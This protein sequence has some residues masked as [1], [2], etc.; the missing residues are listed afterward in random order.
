M[1]QACA[2]LQ[3]P[4][5]TIQPTENL[6]VVGMLDTWPGAWCGLASHIFTPHLLVPATPQCHPSMRSAICNHPCCSRLLSSM[7]RHSS[8]SGSTGWYCCT[9][10]GPNLPASVGFGRADWPACFSRVAVR[11]RFVVAAFG[12]QDL[13]HEVDGRLSVIHAGVNETSVS[14][15]PRPCCVRHVALPAVFRIASSVTS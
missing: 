3:S 13:A 9:R 11:S 7:P 4:E 5:F 12:W 6:L 1:L 2:G 15:L 8:A 10:I 14:G